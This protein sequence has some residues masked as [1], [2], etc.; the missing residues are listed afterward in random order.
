MEFTLSMPYE[1]Y[2]CGETY[3]YYFFL[4]LQHQIY[5]FLSFQT[6]M[7]F[8][9]ILAYGLLSEMTPSNMEHEH[10]S[11]HPNSVQ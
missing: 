10:V 7:N 5:K 2:S 1:N 6:A 3:F 9:E 8:L 11:F 4:Y